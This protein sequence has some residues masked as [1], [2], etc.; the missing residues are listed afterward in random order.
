MIS[1]FFSKTKPITYVV[2][3]VFLSAF[4]VA[5]N[6]R[7]GDRAFL[8]ENFGLAI[9]ALL[10]L[11]I[12]V[13]IIDDMVKKEKISGQSSYTML[14]FVLLMVVFPLTILDNN[15]VF[16][17]LAV[18]FSITKLLQV[19]E[20][21]NIKRKVFIAALLICVASLFY[22]W[23]LLYFIVIV[24]SLNTYGGKN[25][26]NW[27]AALLGIL[28]FLMISSA[29]LLLTNNMG[30]LTEHYKYYILDLDPSAITS[31]LSIKRIIFLLFIVGFAIFTFIKFRKKGGGKLITMRMLL[32]CFI[33]VF[34]LLFL[35]SNRA[36]PILLAFFPAAV[37]LGN[38]IETVKR[39]RIK[40]LVLIVFI[41]MPFLLFL[42]EGLA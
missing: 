41:A 20:A 7:N 24:F 28:T 27:L 13:F 25:I 42:F 29:I 37:F 23:A 21:K 31:K 6:L 10:T 16:S 30:F 11:I 33:L 3:L 9:V 26:K 32:L 34:V 4:Y 17:N 22:K 35:E 18:L 15:A 5:I 19:K 8:S 12:S 14:F 1:S 2:L 39:K 38:Y 40:E 36:S